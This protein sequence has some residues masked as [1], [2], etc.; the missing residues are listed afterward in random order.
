MTV[1]PRCGTQNAAHLPACG[2]CGMLLGRGVPK[3]TL[4]GLSPFQQAAP[5]PG[6]PPPAAPTAGVEPPIVPPPPPPPGEEKATPP[7]QAGIPRGT[8]FGV[9]PPAVTATAAV[10]PARAPNLG[11]TMM[12]IAPEVSRPVPAAESTTATAAPEPGQVPAAPMTRTIL[13]VARP[14]IAPLDPSQRKEPAYP[15]PPLTPPPPAP[16]DAGDATA[17]AFPVSEPVPTLP[18]GVPKPPTN[19][20]P[21]LAAIAVTVAAALVAAGAVVLLLHRGTGPI[22]GRVRLGDDGKE[23]L[24]IVCRECPD[25]TRVA[26]GATS[27]TLASGK[28]SLELRQKLAIGENR[29]ALLLTRPDERKS[30]EVALTVPIDYRVRADTSALAEPLPRLRVAVEARPNSR[31]S[32]D[33]K[34]VPLGPDG[35][36]THDIQVADELDGAEMSVKKLERV[37]DYS[38]TPP[39]GKTETGKVTFQLGI[40]PLSIEAPG[41]RI[42]IDTP[43]FVLSGRSQ[44]GASVSVAERPLKLDGEGRF[45]QVMSVSSEGETKIAVR[46]TIKDHAPRLYSIQIKRVAKLTEEAVR[47][48]AGAITSYAALG[49]GDEKKGSEVALDGSLLEHR[50]EGYS[51]Y[52]LVDVTSGC[53]A[54]PCLVRVVHGAPVK[55]EKGGAVSVFGRVTGSVE[56]ARS[57]TR[58]PEVF[59]SF[60]VPGPK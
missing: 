14:G 6:A 51:S 9:A 41:E 37:V 25:G 12:G 24:E 38:V 39:G 43:T 49:N 42:T 3:G 47:A 13:G 20:V 54:P 53:K 26:A 55:L 28:G 2:L 4:V 18:E 40:T 29:I 60:L 11:R 45:A 31:V 56:G 23:Q 34:D 22:E 27:T 48:R 1:C 10:E 50:S 46:A 36:A 44:P 30:T 21:V 32:V 52:L 19:G 16:F 7:P 15:A 17:N 5:T 35:R 33:G 8:L 57:G 58:V 59:A